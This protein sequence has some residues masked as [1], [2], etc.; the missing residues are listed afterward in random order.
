[1]N[2]LTIKKSWGVQLSLCAMLAF[3]AGCASDDKTPSTTGANSSGSAAQTGSSS[4]S[5]EMRYKAADGRTITIGTCKTSNGGRSFKEPHMDKCWI[6]DGF[7]FK[8]F[9]V[10][11]IAPVTSTAKVHDDEVPVQKIAEDNLQAELKRMIEEKHLGLKVVTDES[12]IKPGVK[13]LWLTDTIVDYGKGGGAA[14]YFVGLYGGG[15]PHL[16][17][18]GV[19][20]DGDKTV[21]T[22]TMRRSGVSGGARTV[23][24]F[25]KDEDIQTQDVHSMVLDLTDFMAAIAGKYQPVN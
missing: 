17:V 23:G 15:Q 18:E 19:M 7:D 25:M 22:Y 16:K 10:I 3:A 20:K 13:A 1:M 24:A 8:G 5:G 11:Y 4:S 9:D 6:A 21:F 2:L 12:A 14:R